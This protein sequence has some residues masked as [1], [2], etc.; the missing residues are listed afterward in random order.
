MILSLEHRYYGKSMPF[1]DSSMDLGNLKYLN[2]EQALSDLALFIH[3]TTKAAKF[4]IRAETPWITVGGSYPGALSA[5]FRSKYPHLTI[6]AVASSAVVLAV[7]KFSQ[8]DEQIYSSALKSG[9]FCVDAIRTVNQYVED[10]VTG[11]EDDRIEFQSQFQAQQLNSREFLF[12]W[13]DV[14]V[15]KIQYGGRTD[16][17]NSLQNKSAE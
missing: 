17:C 10:K 1:G 14:V 16:L 11:S 5:W 2:A 6:G 8:F 4:G 15:L 13:A 3:Y 9:D 12:Y 7:E